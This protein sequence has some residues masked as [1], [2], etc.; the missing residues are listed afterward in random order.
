VIGARISSRGDCARSTILIAKLQTRDAGGID[1]PGD[2]IA[3]GAAM[4]ASWAIS[5]HLMLPLV[6]D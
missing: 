5:R 6:T 3:A 4:P 1:G 2:P